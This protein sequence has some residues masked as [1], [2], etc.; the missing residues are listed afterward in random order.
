L[1]VIL[2]GNLDGNLDGN[3]KLLKF[4]NLKVIVVVEIALKCVVFQFA[5]HQ[6]PAF[7]ENQDAPRTSWQSN[8]D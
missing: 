4:R 7:P 3:F 1:Q 5:C 8:T 6:A 2:H